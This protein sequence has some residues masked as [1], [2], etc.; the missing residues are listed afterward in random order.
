MQGAGSAA[1]AEIRRRDG[2]EQVTTTGD[3]GNTAVAPEC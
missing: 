2:W 1:V 3:D